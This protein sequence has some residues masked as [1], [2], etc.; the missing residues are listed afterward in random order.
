MQKPGKIKLYTG[1]EKLECKGKP[2][3]YSMLQFWQLSLSDI[4]FNMNRG[5]FAEYIVRCALLEGGFDS[6]NEDN[7]TIRPWDITGPYMSSAARVARIEVKSAA[8]IQSDTP[9]EKEPLSLPDSRLVFSIRPAIDWNK[10]KEGAGHNND[11]YVFCHYKA[12]RK[13][14]NILDMDL[15]DFYVYPTFKIEEDPKLNKKNNISLYRLKKLGVLPVSFDQLYNEIMYH[16]QTVAE[17][18]TQNKET[19]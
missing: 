11:L 15:W 19:V 16:I 2:L 9:D 5:T 3:P 1:E 8:S 18:L 12:A 4:L 17:H 7:G 10:E 13:E 6:L 14:Q